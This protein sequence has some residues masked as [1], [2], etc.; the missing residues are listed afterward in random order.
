L[1]RRLPLAEVILAA[2]PVQGS[3]APPAIVSALRSLNQ[4]CT[5]DVI[6]VA[7]GGGSI[8]DLW[9]FNDERVVRAVIDSSAPVISGV[10]HET[11]FTLVDFAADLRAPTPTA[12]AELATPI[13]VMDLKAALSK[14][15]DTLIGET[16]TLFQQKREAAAWLDGRLRLASP[17]RRLQTERQRLDEMSRRWNSAQTHRL[18]IAAEKIRGMERRLLALSPLAVLKRG[19]AVITKN[20]E[21]ISSVAQVREDDA[22]R[23]R[24]QD[25]EFNTRVT[26][27]G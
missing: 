24:V 26:G 3:E 9:A 25:G 5:P 14:I 7:R 22:L 21:V 19:Y 17:G 15:R 16:A 23:V 20:K 12:A 27:N 4:V 1:R 6:L 8:E 13:T 10:G 2:T 11:D 18:E